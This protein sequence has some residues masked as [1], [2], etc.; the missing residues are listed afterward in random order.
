V[1]KLK[2]AE[3]EWVVMAVNPWQAEDAKSTLRV[4]CG[5]NTVEVPMDGRHTGIFV[6]EGDRVTKE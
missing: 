4:P 3:D 6:V 2:L 5:T 1:R